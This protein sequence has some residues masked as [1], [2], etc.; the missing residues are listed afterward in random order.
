MPAL[1]QR[2]KLNS[3]IIKK[4]VIKCYFTSSSDSIKT[5]L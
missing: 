4:Y 5:S 3:V 1:I 2:G